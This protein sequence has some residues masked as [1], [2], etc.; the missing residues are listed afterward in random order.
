MEA[1]GPLKAA[2]Y[3]IQKACLSSSLLSEN[4]KILYHKMYIPF[5]KPIVVLLFHLSIII[6]C[7]PLTQAINSSSSEIPSSLNTTSNS[8]QNP[9]SIRFDCSYDPSS[10]EPRP[11]YEDCLR[12]LPYLTRT[13]LVYPRPDGLPKYYHDSSCQIAI[14][15]ERPVLAVG[16]FDATVELLRQC[17]YFR[18]TGGTAVGVDY[19]VNIY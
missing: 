1:K 7:S 3:N 4:P 2:S 9:P 12:L 5:M 16:V 8:D 13:G 11:Y 15:L 19:T 6:D 18:M 17:Y 14:Y 10:P